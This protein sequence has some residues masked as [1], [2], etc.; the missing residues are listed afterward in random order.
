[1]GRRQ[2][3]GPPPTREWYSINSVSMEFV[4]AGWPLPRKIRMDRLRSLAYQFWQQRGCPFGSPDKDWFHAEKVLNGRPSEVPLPLYA[5][6]IER[7]TS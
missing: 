1:M 3:D 2:T 6:G 5:F 4:D 7:W